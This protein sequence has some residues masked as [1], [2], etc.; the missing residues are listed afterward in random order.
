MAREARVC[1]SAFELFGTAASPS[2]AFAV[3][4]DARAALAA[5]A[6]AFAAAF[7]VDTVLGVMRGFPPVSLYGV[8]TWQCHKRGLAFVQ[9]KPQAGSLGCSRRYLF[10]SLPCLS[11]HPVSVCHAASS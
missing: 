10:L 1:A 6:T 9:V 3:A 4:F 7:V 5:A 11:R 2:V 8:P